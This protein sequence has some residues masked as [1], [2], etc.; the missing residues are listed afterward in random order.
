MNYFNYEKM[1]KMITFHIFLKTGFD[2]YDAYW[3]KLM[4]ILL[5]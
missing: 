2:Y 4:R 3:H 1:I 5:L